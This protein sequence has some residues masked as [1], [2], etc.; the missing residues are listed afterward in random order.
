VI[1]GLIVNVHIDSDI[2]GLTCRVLPSN[3]RAAP[4]RHLEI[5]DSAKV[6]GNAR[7][8]RGLTCYLSIRA[9]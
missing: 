9:I 4:L 2:R 5:R 1:S 6:T 8:T 7:Q 3:S